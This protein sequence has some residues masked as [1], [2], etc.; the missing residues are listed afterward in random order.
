MHRGF[1]V[2]ALNGYQ[3][4]IL[5]G[6][7]QC[8]GTLLL[9]YKSSFTCELE[10]ECKAVMWTA[11]HDVLQIFIAAEQSKRIRSPFHQHSAHQMPSMSSTLIG[12]YFSSAIRWP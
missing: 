6:K 7:L 2:I 3:H 1:K 9:A 4:G 10:V 5:E 12:S 8:W 11:A